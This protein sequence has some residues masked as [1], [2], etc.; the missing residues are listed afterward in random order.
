VLRIQ[1]VYPGFPILILSIP[2]PGDPGSNNST[3]RG[4]G[5]KFV[6]LPFFVATNII[7]LEMILFLTR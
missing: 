3:K 2:D 1:D 4:G 7:K 6:V 5:K